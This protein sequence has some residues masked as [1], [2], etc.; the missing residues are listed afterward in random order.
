MLAASQQR[1]GEFTHHHTARALNPATRP[2]RSRTRHAL[3]QAGRSFGRTLCYRT[4][5]TAIFGGSGHNFA[6]PCVSSRGVAAT[7]IFLPICRGPAC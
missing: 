7:S 2:C 4:V 1:T 6:S 5:I 3:W